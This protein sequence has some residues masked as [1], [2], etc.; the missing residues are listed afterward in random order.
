MEMEGV[1]V[2]IVWGEERVEPIRIRYYG[3][4]KAALLSRNQAAQ[5][6]LC[7]GK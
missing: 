1:S 3:T 6:V 2:S 7:I 5:Y 4:E